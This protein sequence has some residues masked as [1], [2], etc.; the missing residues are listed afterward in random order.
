MELQVFIARFLPASQS[1]WLDNLKLNCVL[2]NEG[3]SFRKYYV[4]TSEWS[5]SMTE[6][7]F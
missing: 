1:F 5:K 4:Y 3:I 6:F 2:M 7:F